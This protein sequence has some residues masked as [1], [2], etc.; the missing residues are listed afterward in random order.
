MCFKL[1]NDVNYFAYLKIITMTQKHNSYKLFNYEFIKNKYIYYINTIYKWMGIKSIRIISNWVRKISCV[2]FQW[3]ITS[4]LVQK[5][6]EIQHGNDFVEFFSILWLKN[7]INIL[8]LKM[9]K[10]FAYFKLL[11]DI[12]QITVTKID[13]I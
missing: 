3:E 12:Y 11:I 9:W 4:F 13:R 1:C 8:V 5:F 10:M 7:V 2:N 6:L